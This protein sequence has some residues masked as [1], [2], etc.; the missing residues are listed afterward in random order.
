MLLGSLLHGL[1]VLPGRAMVLLLRD[2]RCFAAAAA[3]IIELGAAHL[4]AADDLDG[5]DHRRV[6]REYALHTLAVRDLAHREILIEA[7]A[8]TPDANALIG[9][10]ATA[11][12][13]DHLVVDENRIARPEVRDLLA[14]GKLGHLLFFELL[15][16]VN[17]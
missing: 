15:N 2:P 8:R 6:K 3:Q 10:N 1:G 17:G 16:K 11:L 4:A 5:I 13:F 7:G 9:L 14:G 12:A